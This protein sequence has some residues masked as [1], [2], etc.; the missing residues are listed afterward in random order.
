MSARV[1]AALCDQLLP[2]NG[3][4]PALPQWAVLIDVCSGALGPSKFPVMVD[5]FCRLAF[6]DRQPHSQYQKATT[7]NALAHALAELSK[8][9]NGSVS[10]V[11]FEGGY[12]CRWIAAGLPLWPNGYSV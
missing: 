6:T 11:T 2:S 12:D 5:G 7:A 1:L 9:S 3:L 4:S 10:T 8:V